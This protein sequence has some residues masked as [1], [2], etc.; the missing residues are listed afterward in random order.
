MNLAQTLPENS[1]W[2][3]A[4]RA[5]GEAHQDDTIGAILFE[6]GRLNLENT[7][8]IRQ[9]QREKGLAFGAAGIALGVLNAEDIQFALARQFGYPYLFEGDGQVSTELVAAYQPFSQQAETLRALRTQLKLRWFTG[10]PTQKMLAVVGTAHRD[11]RSYLMA[12]LAVEFSQLGE[13]TLLIDADLRC[14][15]QHALFNIVNRTGLQPCC[16]AALMR[17]PSRPS[18]PCPTFRYCRRARYRPIRRSCSADRP[19]DAF[20]SR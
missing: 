4:M 11:G 7:E 12:N 19:L 20:L 16:R 6:A 2:L 15:R 18:A 17:R 5:P 9:L 8:R 14:P 3:R 1:H 13:R 10:V